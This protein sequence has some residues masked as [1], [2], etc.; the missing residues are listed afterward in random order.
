MFVIKTGCMSSLHAVHLANGKCPCGGCAHPEEVSVA[1]VSSKCLQC[2]VVRQ[3]PDFPPVFPPLC[4]PS[5]TKK[6]V[7]LNLC[8]HKVAF[9]E[10]TA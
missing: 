8:C 6:T 1:I 5:G 4:D 9:R 10:F 3:M 7:V 2:A